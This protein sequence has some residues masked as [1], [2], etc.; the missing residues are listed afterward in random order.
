[1]VGAAHLKIHIVIC[2]NA[3]TVHNEISAKVISQDY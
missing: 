1:M 2:V 3:K